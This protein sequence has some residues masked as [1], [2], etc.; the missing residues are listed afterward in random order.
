L[1]GG[2][3]EPGREYL[4]AYFWGE[5]SQ[6][7]VEVDKYPFVSKAVDQTKN[8]VTSSTLCSTEASFIP[9]GEDRSLDYPL[10]GVFFTNSVL[11]EQTHNRTNIFHFVLLQFTS[12]HHSTMMIVIT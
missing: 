6:N 8:P 4:D 1:C 9:V 12:N 2:G 10:T 7:A 3:R 11:R 5:V